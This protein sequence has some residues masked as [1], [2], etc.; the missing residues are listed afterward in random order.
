MINQNSAHPLEGGN[1]HNPKNPQEG[2]W[3]SIQLSTRAV[4]IRSKAG[5]KHFWEYH[6]G[7]ALDDAYF[8]YQEH[9]AWLQ[10]LF[11]HT[12][13]KFVLHASQKCTCKLCSQ[14]FKG[15]S[16]TVSSSKRHNTKLT[17]SITFFGHH[18]RPAKGKS[19]STAKFRKLKFT[20]VD[21]FVWIFWLVM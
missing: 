5:D 15:R 9:E 3:I 16:F 17:Q 20:A 1:P 4:L 14:R 13:H 6:F 11:S 8:V 2:L 18:Y 10:A 12:I 21:D 19:I 7:N